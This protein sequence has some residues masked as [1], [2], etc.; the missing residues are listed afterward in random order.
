MR[1][2]AER[3]PGRIVAS[4]LVCVALFSFAD[5][6]PARADEPAVMRFVVLSR[7]DAETLAVAKSPDVAAARA[8]VDAAGAAV[9]QARGTNGFSL[10]VLY[11]Q[12][13]QSGGAPN[14]T[15]AQRLGT[16]QLQTTLGDVNALSPLVA[17]AAASLRQAIADELTAERSERLKVVGLY[18]AALQT[19]A[20]L[21]AKEDAVTSA[22]DFEAD[23]RDQYGSGKLP[24]IDL[25][26]AQVSLAKAR[27]DE[28]GAQGMDANAT[29]ALARE[30][31][32]NVADLRELENEPP[33]EP[34]VIDD[35]RAITRAFAQRPELRSADQNVAAA[36]AGLAAARRAVIPPVTVSGGY[37]NGVDAG[38]VIGSPAF[39]VSMQIPLSGI[40]GARIAA[41]AAAVRG[42]EAKREGAKRALALEV[43][44]AARTAAAAIIARAETEAS[45]EAATSY[46]HYATAQYKTSRSGGMMV[47]DATDIYDQA[48]IDDITAAYAVLQAQATL[49]IELS[50]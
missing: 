24:Y 6:R 36:E 21:L 34:D 10:V 50:P 13:P 20:V 40:A 38:T 30:T 8:N 5:V 27:A 26:R 9:A 3:R 43:G 44:A 11:A 29:D 41:Q 49:D 48:V 15:W 28:A 19:R 16:Y 12:V 31:G 22:E 17:A 42:A 7:H 14:L 18:F 33:L 35:D 45:L 39:S 25:L 37:I 1:N 23:V 47:K 4:A 2:F 32:R 46:L